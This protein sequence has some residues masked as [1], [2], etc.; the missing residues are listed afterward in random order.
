MTR[1]INGIGGSSL[2]GVSGLTSGVRIFECFYSFYCAFLDMF[3]L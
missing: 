3:V 1:I 2:S